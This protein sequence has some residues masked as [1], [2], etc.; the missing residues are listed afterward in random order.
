MQKLCS[1]RT[2]SLTHFCNEDVSARRVRVSVELLHEVFNGE[3]KI[4]SCHK[5]AERTYGSYGSTVHT[6]STATFAGAIYCTHNTKLKLKFVLLG[7]RTTPG[8]SERHSHLLRD[9]AKQDLTTS[10]KLQPFKL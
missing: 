7:M 1:V 10:L 5:W 3:K 8:R 4:S 6:V 2:R 9:V